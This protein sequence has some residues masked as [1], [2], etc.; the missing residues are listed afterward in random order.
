M[1]GKIGPSGRAWLRRVFAGVMV[2]VLATGV[3]V[4]LQDSLNIIFKVK[5]DPDRALWT[6]FRNRFLS[7]GMI[8]VIAFLL[9]V[10]LMLSTALGMLGA[11][12][13]VLGG[14]TVWGYR[15]DEDRRFG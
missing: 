4:E 2:L 8:L 3:F 7:F 13:I 6:M 1:S 5:P 12:T 9:L 10:S 14:L 15:R 11:W